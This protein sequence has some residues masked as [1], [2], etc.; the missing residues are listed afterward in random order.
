LRTMGEIAEY[1]GNKMLEKKNEKLAPQAA[2]AAQNTVEISSINLEG[3]E[4]FE[5]IIVD[6]PFPNVSFPNLTSAKIQ[7]IQ[8]QLGV[9]TIL[10]AKLQQAN[11]Q[12]ELATEFSS[13]TLIAI[14]LS[15]L[16]PIHQ[17]NDAVNLSRAVF[18]NAKRVAQTL[19][20][21]A[22]A[23]ILVESLDGNFGIS[24]EVPQN[25]AWLGA[26]AGLAKTAAREW[27]NSTVKIIDIANQQRDAEKIAQKLFDELQKGYDHFIEIGLPADGK[28]ITID[29]V[30]VNKQS[31]RCT[32]DT[33]SV[34]VATG[35]A[36]GVTAACLLELA[37]QYHP[38]IAIIGRTPLMPEPDFCI[39]ANTEAQLKQ[40]FVNQAKAQNQTPNL[41]DI[42]KLTANI[43][44]NREVKRNIEALQQAGS[45]VLYFPADAQ[46]K[47]QVDAVLKQVRKEWGPIT[48][49]IHGAGVLADKLIADKTPEQFDYVFNT[50]VKGLEI[51]LELTAQDPL[52]TICLFSSVTASFGNVGQVD[53]GMANE[54]LNKIANQ[55]YFR[56]GAACVVKSINWG[57][58]ESG[59]VNAALKDVFAKQGIQLIP[60]ATGARIFVEEITRKGEQHAEVV[61]GKGF[62]DERDKKKIR[63]EK[64]NEVITIDPI[65]FSFLNDHTVKNAVVIPLCLI[66]DW[67]CQS[68]KRE[69]GA[70]QYYFFEDIKVLKGARLL[71]FQES[72]SFNV[73]MQ[74]IA[75]D[76]IAL[77]L[78]AGPAKYCSAKLRL[79]GML[80]NP[81]HREQ[82]G[83]AWPWSEKEVYKK[84]LLFHGPAFQSIQQLHTVSQT[85]GKASL[86]SHHWKQYQGEIDVPL[87][88]GALQIACL[89]TRYQ[90]Q[91]ASL[92]MSIQQ[93]IY[94]PQQNNDEIVTC[95]F[96]AVAMGHLKCKFDMQLIRPNGTVM[97]MIKQL[98]MLVYD[99]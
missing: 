91:K 61:I 85:G 57:P 16:N 28:R 67:F 44:G 60:L 36:K 99:E 37:K 66:L 78:L 70:Q 32:P 10:K 72:T 23:Y 43:L 79:A 22:G 76:V 20:Q 27:T 4:R 68:I 63:N 92:P 96:Q 7:I 93:L 19:T 21:N 18:L 2:T 12:A 41:R 95:E 62:P 40:A 39:N 9:A 97:A 8:D 84:R 33:N 35:G 50:K 48:G 64:I 38:K 24:K 46:N 69:L 75:D 90:L 11:Y 42:N 71:N 83:A 30:S 58:W 89:W 3:M 98:E 6:A 45:K 5:P 56:R 86:L 81:M 59:M 15:G 31:T 55:E 73:T 34:F 87:L 94:T 1:V 29:R 77:E 47:A 52:Q 53:Y 80:S 13:D 14:D 49:I 82:N 74:G 51:L 65:H 88:D 17:I 25:R 54:V 26:L